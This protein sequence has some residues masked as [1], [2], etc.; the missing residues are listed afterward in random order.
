MSYVESSLDE[1]TAELV[2]DLNYKLK[3]NWTK[4]ERSQGK[5]I[6]LKPGDIKYASKMR[7]KYTDAGWNVKVIIGIKSGSKREAWLNFKVPKWS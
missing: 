2:D 7:D 5:Y 1:M 4:R 3:L 6:K